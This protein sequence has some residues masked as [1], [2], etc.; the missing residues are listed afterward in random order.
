MLKRLLIVPFLA[1]C[2]GPTSGDYIFETTGTEGDCAFLEGDDTGEPADPEP[3]TITVAEEGDAVRLSIWNPPQGE[4]KVCPLD[5]NVFTC[6]MESVSDVRPSLDAVLTSFLQIEGGWT[7]GSEMQG[8]TTYDN[9]C[10]GAD[11]ETAFGAV[12]CAGSANWTATL[13][14]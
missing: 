5:G 10:S 1:G 3:V 13:Q 7:S 14:E 8:Q 12:I 4:P 11:C 9:T 2:W 6:T